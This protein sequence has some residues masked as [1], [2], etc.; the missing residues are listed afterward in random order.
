MDVSEDRN[1]A[2]TI[3]EK[4]ADTGTHKVKRAE[5]IFSAGNNKDLAKTLEG[6]VVGSKKKTENTLYDIVTPQ[7]NERDEITT[8][9]LMTYQEKTE[10]KKSKNKEMQKDIFDYAIVTIWISTILMMLL[11]IIFIYSLVESQIQ[12][13]TVN[14][15]IIVS[16]LT[17]VSTTTEYL[18]DS[19]GKLLM[20]DSNKPTVV[21]SVTTTVNKSQNKSEITWETAATVIGSIVGYLTLVFG[22]LTIITKYSFPE[23]ED[24]NIKDIVKV[25]LEN[26]LEQRKIFAGLKNDKNSNEEKEVSTKE[27]AS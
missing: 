18:K 2:E 27:K 6:T 13:S 9:L 23:T 15:N 19:E 16:E 7:Q 12:K 17:E 24:A 3:S 11:A 25:I 20:D 26:D 14:N 22:L 21:S 4:T 10:E 8:K 1:V 5:E